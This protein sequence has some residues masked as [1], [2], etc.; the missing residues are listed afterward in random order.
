MESGR[1]RE[2]G[3][4]A[5]IFEAPQHAYTSALLEA[6]PDFEPGDYPARSA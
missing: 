1:V 6:V 4:A 3:P 5:G 2:D